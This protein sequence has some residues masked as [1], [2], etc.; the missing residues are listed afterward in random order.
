MIECQKPI[1]AI[2][3]MQQNSWRGQSNTRVDCSLPF[4]SINCENAKPI[5]VPN[6]NTFADLVLRLNLTPPINRDHGAGVAD[7]GVGFGPLMDPK[8]NVTLL[9]RLP[10]AHT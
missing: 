3:L 1:D 5:I 9:T 6:A 10:L 2:F 4:G 7:C 8:V